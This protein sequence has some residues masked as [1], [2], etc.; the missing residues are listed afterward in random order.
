MINW[1]LNKLTPEWDCVHKVEWRHYEVPYR[2]GNCK[3]CGL[4]FEEAY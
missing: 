2:E 3:H 4:H 1:L